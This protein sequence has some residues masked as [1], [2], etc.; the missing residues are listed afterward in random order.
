VVTS[1]AKRQR[2]AAGVDK[3]LLT[4]WKMVP[5]SDQVAYLCF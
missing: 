2:L 5:V 1:P 3:N 4:S